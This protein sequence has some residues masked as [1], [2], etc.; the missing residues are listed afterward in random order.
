MSTFLAAPAQSGSLE[1]ETLRDELVAA[2]R[3][4][5]EARKVADDSTSADSEANLARCLLALREY[6]AATTRYSNA[7]ISNTDRILK[8]S[9]TEAS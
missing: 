8:K 9:D 4:Y 3:H 6:N 7:L 5:E 2:K 1:L